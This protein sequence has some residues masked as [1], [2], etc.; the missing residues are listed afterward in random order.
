MFLSS[1][2]AIIFIRQNDSMKRLLLSIVVLFSFFSAFK[3]GAQ[4]NPTLPSVIGIYND[5]VTVS[6][7]TVSGAYGYEYV[8]QPS[9]DPPPSSGTLTSANTVHVGGLLPHTP[10]KVWLR[11]YCGVQGY[12]TWNYTSFTTLCGQADSFRVKETTPTSVKLDWLKVNGAAGYEY[13]IDVNSAD[14]IIP[15]YQ[16]TDDS[17]T[18]TT[19]IPNTTYYAHMRT[20]CGGTFSAWK[21]TSSF[22][23]AFPAGISNPKTT[24][25]IKSYPNPVTDVLYVEANDKATV[26]IINAVGTVVYQTVCNKGKL[27]IDMKA[28]PSGFYLLKYSDSYQTTTT[29]ISKY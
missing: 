5:S 6:W 24:G 2:I 4:C 10:H 27:G 28:M 25:S 9:V 13:L 18:V 12:S 14:P 29:R 23:A 19:L 21:T 11:S 26:T 22:V 15:G 3:A 16:V 1:K 8:V 20:D 17:V 7:A